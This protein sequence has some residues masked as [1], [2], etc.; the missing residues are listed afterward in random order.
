MNKKSAQEVEKFIDALIGSSYTHNVHLVKVQS[1]EDD[2]YEVLTLMTA[3]TETALADL[4]TVSFYVT[5]FTVIYS[6]DKAKPV[7]I[8]YIDA[9]N[10]TEYDIY[11][12]S[13]SK[14]V[15]AEIYDLLESKLKKHHEICELEEPEDFES[16]ISAR[17]KNKVKK[18]FENR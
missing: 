16:I 12:E 10:T 4:P 5:I 8:S 11:Q 14:T 7:E 1:V 13:L 3:D 9:G 15:A 2:K 18:I 17:D 6:G